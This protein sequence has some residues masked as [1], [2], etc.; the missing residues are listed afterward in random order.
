MLPTIRG[1]APYR[2]LVADLQSGVA[3]PGLGLPRAARLPVTAALSTDL[4]WPVVIV[5]DRA[6]HSLTLMDELAFWAP[7]ANRLLFPEPSPLFYEQAAWG[8]A[9][10]RDRLLVLAALAAYHLPGAQ[11]PEQPPILVTTARA[12]MTRTLPRRDLIKNTR[13]IRI[14]QTIQ[15]DTL[16]R[17][18]ADTGYQPTEI[19]LEPGQFSRR[20][21][22]L[23][24]WPPAEPLPARLDFFGDEIDTMRQFDPATQRTVKTLDRLL[25]M[26]AREVLPGYAA[27]QGVEVENLDEF[28]LP[29]VHPAPASLLDYL[30]QQALVLFED[31]DILRATVAEYEEQAVRMRAESIA[32]GTLP[33]DFPV[34]YLSWSEINDTLNG[35]ASLELGYSTAEEPSELARLFSPGPRF[36]GRLKQLLDT[37][38][39]QFSA[40]DRLIYRLPAG[41]AAEGVVG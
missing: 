26:P 16:I 32:E 39:D 18:W 7:D 17:Q 11:K 22:I 13:T 35:H 33:A 15:P 5:T 6:D 20:G 24:I 38:V 27:G 41:L 25:I 9:A 4:R 34:P 29:R 12:L 40:G 19:V 30:P 10:R 31:L 8:S 1:I 36:G 28:Y 23:D 3:L 21:G 2:Q 14:G 37:M